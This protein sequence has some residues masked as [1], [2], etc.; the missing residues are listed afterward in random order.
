MTPP[1]VVCDANVVIKWFHEEGEQDAAEA[2]ALLT[3]YADRRASLVI[4][5]LT[6]YEVGNA[7]VRGVGVEPAAVATVL[8][9]LGDLCPVITPTRQELGVAARLASDHGF[10]FYDAACAA[11]AQ[12]RGGMAATMDAALLHAGQGLTPGDA[13]DRL[14]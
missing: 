12:V 7:L 4:L 1:I 8:E 2:R 5:D 9:A 6:P 11:V 3:A 14:A 13:L 10:T